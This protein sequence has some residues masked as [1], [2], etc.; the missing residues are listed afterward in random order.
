ML[1]GKRHPSEHL[2]CHLDGASSQ[3]L[4]R[5]GD[6]ANNTLSRSLSLSLS[7][8]TNRATRFANC[9]IT[10]PESAKK[11]ER[12]SENKVFHGQWEADKC[13]TN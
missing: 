3:L 1:Q 6:G 9:C 5:C 11:R 7:L 12:K 13:S 2:D 8:S 10:K 4:G